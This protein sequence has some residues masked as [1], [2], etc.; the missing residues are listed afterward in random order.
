MLFPKGADWT[1]ENKQLAQTYVN[2]AQSALISLYLLAEAE[3][4]SMHRRRTTRFGPQ[5]SVAR[6][7]C[8]SG[9]KMAARRA[10]VIIR[11]SLVMID[12]D[13]VQSM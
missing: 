1:Q 8:W 12:M 10:I 11:S 6:F 2:T 13:Q 7:S 5:S 9:E 3:K 4:Q